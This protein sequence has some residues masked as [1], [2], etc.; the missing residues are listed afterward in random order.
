MLQNLYNRVNERG[1]QMNPL[2]DE[3]KESGKLKEALLIGKN[4]VNKEPGDTESIEAYVD[5]LLSLAANLPAIE[6]RKQFIGEANVALSFYEENAEL[7]PEVIKQIETYRKR[8]GETAIEIDKIEREKAEA[9]IREIEEE[10]TKQIKE[11]YSIKQKLEKAR[12]QKDFEKELQAVSLVDAKIKHDYLTEEQKV[13]YDQLSKLCTE[14]I[15]QKMR[16]FEYENNIAYNKQAVAAFDK[17][18][19]S[20]K[21][22]ES[23]YKNQSQLFGLVSA[24]LFAYDAG[25]LFNET[26]IFYNHVYSYIFGKL[27]DDGKFAL[28]RYSIECERKLG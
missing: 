19:H 9:Q 3:Y 4:M 16:A 11:L 13:H 1:K 24:T 17:A 5:L 28:T 7:T 18:F 20:F 2:F 8:L 22:D 12:T 25:R 21:N 14:V 23:R 27:D 15:S 6:E 26:L 10:N